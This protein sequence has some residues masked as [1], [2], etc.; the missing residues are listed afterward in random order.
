MEY[1]KTSCQ[2]KNL[3]KIAFLS[4]S[5]HIERLDPSVTRRSLEFNVLLI[6]LK[7]NITHQNGH[8]IKRTA[9]DVER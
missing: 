6:L 4:I 8:Q 9:K 3:V 2:V 5:N 1:S 7:C